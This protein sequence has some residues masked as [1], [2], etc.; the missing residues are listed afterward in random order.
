MH[1]IWGATV[2]QSEPWVTLGES[3]NPELTPFF[4]LNLVSA[5][6]HQQSQD[7][8]TQTL[9]IPHS[10]SF[11]SWYTFQRSRGGSWEI[12]W[13]VRPRVGWML[14]QHQN[15]SQVNTTAHRE[16]PLYFLL[17]QFSRHRRRKW[18]HRNWKSGYNS[19]SARREDLGQEP[20][21]GMEGGRR[22]RNRSTCL[23]VEGPWSCQKVLCT[24][25]R[26]KGY[27]FSHI[28]ATAFPN[29]CESYNVVMWLIS[30]LI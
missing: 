5:M 27:M 20:S 10:W 14:E 24:T 8:K 7:S 15:Y 2:G 19:S 18:I 25:Y 11:W 21:N 23:P 17:T 26:L 28:Y 12:R 30:S 4:Y 13:P 6:G 16:F 22:G 29:V 3:L 1:Q 9:F